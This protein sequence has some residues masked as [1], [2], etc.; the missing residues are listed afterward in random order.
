MEHTIFG[1]GR[2]DGNGCSADLCA[3]ALSRPDMP[4]ISSVLIS[5]RLLSPAGTISTQLQHSEPLVQR[6]ALCTQPPRPRRQTVSSTNHGQESTGTDYFEYK[7][8]D[9]SDVSNEAARAIVTV[10][11]PTGSFLDAFAYTVTADDTYNSGGGEA[12]SVA[13]DLSAVCAKLGDITAVAKVW[14]NEFDSVS[15]SSWSSALSLGDTVSV[16]VTIFARIHPSRR[17]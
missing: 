11:P 1:H 10:E 6:P 14:A 7:L 13:V 16:D 17:R 2:A 4:P 9:C 12:T 5:I 8:T 15:L 3:P